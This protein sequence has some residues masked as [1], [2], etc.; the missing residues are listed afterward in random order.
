MKDD[1]KLARWLNDGMDKQELEAFMASPDFEI[2]DR[3][4]KYSAQLT[5]PEADMDA[6]YN[7]ISQNRGREKKS[8]IRT[9]S[10][11]LSRIAAVLVLAL[12]VTYYFY[13][14]R[15][16]T[17][18]A[19]AGERTEFALP[20]NSTVMLN[21]GSTA[22]YRP[23]NW[24][25]KRIVELEGEAFF[26]VAKGE[27]FDVITPQG[28]VTVVGTEFNVRSREGRLE[29]TCFEGK[30]K[31]SAGN[32]SL[33]LTPG[34]SVIFEKG[35]IMDMPNDENLSPGWLN[36]EPV[37]ESES[38]AGVIAE[39]ERQYNIKIVLKGKQPKKG[40]SGSI[41]MNDLNSALESIKVTYHL[42]AERTGSTIVLST[43]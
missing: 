13:T 9:L 41:P 7:R 43:E 16:T 11:W 27:T 14:T 40:F 12:C 21:S 26:K 5:V 24:E 6:L 33:L 10:P 2:Y 20:D 4:K 30:V 17:Q 39:M 22:E 36:Y 37:F 34:K 28:K 25:G 29:V 32:E 42:K 35:K 3:I 23:W 8:R 18:F 19:A 38:L 1:N 31:V 15:T